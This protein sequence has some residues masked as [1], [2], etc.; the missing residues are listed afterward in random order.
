MAELQ[1]PAIFNALRRV[2]DLSGPVLRMELAES[3]VPVIIMDD[4]RNV[5]DGA[6]NLCQGQALL[7]AIAG[8]FAK[9]TLSQ[10]PFANDTIKRILVDAIYLATDGPGG[11]AYITLTDSPAGGFTPARSKQYSKRFAAVQGQISAGTTAV[12]MPNASASGMVYIPSQR[13]IEVRPDQPW[14][15]DEPGVANLTVQRVD[16]LAS[17]GI[18]FEW[19]EDRRP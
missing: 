7:G 8:Q 4:A 3:V 15:L 13:M 1:S 6:F 19:R 12:A 16:A 18:M 10:G 14:I 11:F 9:V 2:V 5:A 17:L